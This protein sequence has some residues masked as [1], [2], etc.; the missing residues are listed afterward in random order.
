MSHPVRWTATA[1][2]LACLTAGAARAWPAAQVRPALAARE[3]GSL[4]DEARQWLASLF[5]REKPSPEQQRK[6]GCGMDPDGRQVPC[7]N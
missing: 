6:Y 1:L 5:R 7:S 2:V 3:A 4:L